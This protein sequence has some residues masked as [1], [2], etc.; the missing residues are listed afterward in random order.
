V[1]V[2]VLAGGVAAAAWEELDGGLIRARVARLAVDGAPLVCADLSAARAESGAVR[3][4][5]GSAA[6]VVFV[7][8]N[9]S[10]VQVAPIP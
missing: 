5:G 4:V 9:R 7:D 3:L 2:A 10:R 6:S 8:F 1:Q